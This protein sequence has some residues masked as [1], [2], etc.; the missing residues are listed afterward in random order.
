MESET[1]LRAILEQVEAVHFQRL[2]GADD[3]ADDDDDDD[4]AGGGAD[5]G[6]GGNLFAKLTGGIADI[7][8]S[9]VKSTVGAVTAV[10]GG[11]DDDVDDGGVGGKDDDAAETSGKDNVKTSGKERGDE[12]KGLK[13]QNA[14]MTAHTRAVADR[15][16]FVP[17]STLEASRRDKLR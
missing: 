3:D 12:Q 16:A 5:G 2:E 8:K 9:T 6:F 4:F 10:A 13:Q 15:R 11:G 14:S 7:A 1:L 17:A